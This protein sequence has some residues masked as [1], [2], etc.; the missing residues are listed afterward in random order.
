MVFIR[1]FS[2]AQSDVH[3]ILVFNTSGPREELVPCDLGDV[4]GYEMV[5]ELDADYRLTSE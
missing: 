1:G 3:K 4:K 5:A 2:G